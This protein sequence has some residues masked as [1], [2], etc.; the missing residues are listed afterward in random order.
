MKG[1]LIIIVLIF[2]LLIAGCTT[3][4]VVQNNVSQPNEP[5]ITKSI[6]SIQT[7]SVSDNQPKDITYSDDNARWNLY[8]D[9]Y[10]HF[11]IYKAND[12]I[13]APKDSQYRE[14]M[15]DKFGT[16]E[17]MRKYVWIYPPTYEER[18]ITSG[19]GAI[20]I[21]GYTLS[22]PNMT[23]SPKQ[24][25]DIF[26]GS[27]ASQMQND[28]SVTNVQIDSKEYLINGNPATHLT[29]DSINGGSTHEHYQVVYNYSFYDLQWVGNKTYAPTASKIMRTFDPY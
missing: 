28:K 10:D 21:S 25:N 13:V 22:K 11:R 4:S 14:P 7:T 16:I 20:V 6:E 2:S 19:N 26:S 27:F 24:L 12:W 5:S 1:Y 15:T 9:S 3:Q 8:T 18:Y 23:Y 29:F 17:Q